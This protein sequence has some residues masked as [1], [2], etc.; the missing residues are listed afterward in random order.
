MK[1]IS[2]IY[3]P[4]LPDARQHFISVV[5]MDSELQW[6]E[7]LKWVYSNEVG[8]PQATDTYTVTELKVMGMIGVYKKENE[9]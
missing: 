9:E 7:Y 3:N 6:R 2:N 4:C 8:D 1:H 5:N